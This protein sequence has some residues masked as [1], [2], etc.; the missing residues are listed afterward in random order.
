MGALELVAITSQIDADNARE[1]GREV[2]DV[3]WISQA[4][5]DAAERDDQ[6]GDESEWY[7]CSG[8][9]ARFRAWLTPTEATV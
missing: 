7:R 2:I 6:L 4:Q 9:R 5:L 3:A 1:I 8:N